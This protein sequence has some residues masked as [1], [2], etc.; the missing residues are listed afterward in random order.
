M[1]LRPGLQLKH[2]QSFRPEEIPRVLRNMFEKNTPEIR[3]SSPQTFVISSDNIQISKDLWPLTTPQS[4]GH[5]VG[6]MSSPHKPMN[7]Q[8][9]RTQR[10][11][12]ACRGDRTRQL[13][14]ARTKELGNVT[15]KSQRCVTWGQRDSGSRFTLKAFS[16]T[17]ARISQ[18]QKVPSSTCFYRGLSQQLLAQPSK[19]FN[20]G[21]LQGTVLLTR[22]GPVFHS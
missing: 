21:C 22:L 7:W 11:V 18:D 5:S 20:T 9:Q 14:S 10:D 13:G 8:K 12:V 1:K 17:S 4:T 16:L 2:A 3:D 6:G 19:S 15:R